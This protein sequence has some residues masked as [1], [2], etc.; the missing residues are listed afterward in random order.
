[1]K[2]GYNDKVSAKENKTILLVIES[3]AKIPDSGTNKQ[4]LSPVLVE[5]KKKEG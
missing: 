3:N 1:M 4:M 2:W 5:Q